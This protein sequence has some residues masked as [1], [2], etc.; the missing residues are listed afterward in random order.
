MS[1]FD[2]RVAERGWCPGRGSAGNRSREHG[3]PRG[4]RGLN[5]MDQAIA[6]ATK[7]LRSSPNHRV[8]ERVP[9]VTEW[10]LP[11]AESEVCRACLVDCETTGLGDADEVIELAVVPFDYEKAAGRVV[12]VH[13]DAILNRFREP[14]IQIPEDSTKVHGI[15]QE[16]V[17]GQVITPEQ[18]DAALNGSRVVISHHAGFDRP[19]L[20]RPFPAFESLCWAC[21]YADIDWRGEGL[22][23]SKLDYLLF[24]FGWF[25]DG[26]RAL[27]DV[28]ATLWLLTLPL[29]VSGKPALCELLERARRPLKLVEA[30]GTKRAENDNLK[31][32]GYRWVAEQKAWTLASSDPAAEL[33]WLKAF[34]GWSKGSKATLRGLHPKLRYSSRV[35]ADRVQTPVP[36]QEGA[37]AD[38]AP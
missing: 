9:P 10:K 11:V 36:A 18:I 8:L 13:V 3:G 12:K 20:E 31:A 14:S 27:E 17:A 23:S 24:K 34:S 28:L 19:M 1:W 6:N 22:R 32:R 2:S 16:M 21:S 38:G 7:L 37:A 33:E 35:Y 15:T 30:R 29:P 5:K 26:H 25:F 4:S